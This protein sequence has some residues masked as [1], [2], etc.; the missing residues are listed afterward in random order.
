MKKKSANELEK[1]YSG[2][3]GAEVSLEN[4]K[5][6]SV[7]KMKTKKTD[8]VP[9]EGMVK[10]RQKF[11]RA[12]NYA[13]NILLVPDMQAAYALKS[14]KGLPAFQVAL[15]DF[16]LPPSVTV[17]DVNDYS[18]MVGDQIHVV[19]YDDFAVA[20]VTVTIQDSSGVVVEKGHCV[21]NPLTSNFDYTAT[22]Q[23][24][25]LMGV[26]IIAQA[27]DYPGHVGEHMVTL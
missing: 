3:F 14:R 9:T 18:G 25:N 1:A 12:A 11:A 16:M 10:H 13:K 20:D 4:R 6:K 23:V 2:I 22:V 7:M 19:A 26:M 8:V 5:G 15:T 21:L 24:S 27:R 17:I